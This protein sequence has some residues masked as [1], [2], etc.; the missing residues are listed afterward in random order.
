MKEIWHNL[1]E[2]IAYLPF[3][4]HLLGWCAGCNQVRGLPRW[5]RPRC[6]QLLRP[7]PRSRDFSRELQAP[8]MDRVGSRETWW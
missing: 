7:L 4:L 2:E 5:H 6:P 8:R 3:T 1:V